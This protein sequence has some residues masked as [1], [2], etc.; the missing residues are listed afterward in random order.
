MVPDQQGNFTKPDDDAEVSILLA[1]GKEWHPFRPSPEDFEWMDIGLAAARIPRFN[2]QLSP[3]YACKPWDNYVLGQHLCL[4][5]DLAQ[6]ISPELPVDT[7]L[8]IH[9]HDGEEPV[10]GLGDPSAPVKHSPRFRAPFKEYFGPILD[11]IADKARIPRVLM[12]N[13]PAV[14][15]FDKLAYRIENAHLRGIGRETCPTIP[16]QH[17]TLSGEFAVWS[18]L[19]AYEAWMERLNHLLALKNALDVRNG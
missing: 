4:C 10:G 11:V 16:P 9:T 15:K 3:K 1:S 19:V 6:I 2:G 8:A 14:K 13:D 12:H 7:L 5:S 17:L 18:T